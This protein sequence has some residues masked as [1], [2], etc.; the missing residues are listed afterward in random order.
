M[1]TTKSLNIKRSIFLFSYKHSHNNDKPTKNN[2]PTKEDTQLYENINS[3]FVSGERSTIPQH[4]Y[5]KVTVSTK[6]TNR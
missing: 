2:K 1:V 4:V 5:D 3:N 6:H